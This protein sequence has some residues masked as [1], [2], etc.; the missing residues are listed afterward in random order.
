MA[1]K[2]GLKATDPAKAAAPEG[3]RERG[4]RERLRRI[5]RAALEV[6][7]Q[8]GYEDANTREIAR[9]AEV[10]VGTIFVYAPTKRD[11]LYLVLNEDLDA[12]QAQ[13]SASIPPDGPVVARIMALLAPIYAYFAREPVMA[14]AALREVLPYSR[15]DTATSEQGQRYLRRMEGWLSGLTDILVEASR[16]GELNLGADTC[17]S[18]GR[19]IFNIHLGEVRFWVQSQTPVLTDA[20]AELESLVRLVVGDKTATPRK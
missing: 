4:K 15:G 6:F 8:H 18:M 5:K 2:I 9:L 1:A 10:S 13:A 19:A 12:I 16:R 14:R 17:I 7:R 3:L 20:V 11:L